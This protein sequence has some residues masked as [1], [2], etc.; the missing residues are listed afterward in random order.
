MKCI[1]VKINRLGRVR[2]SEILVSPLMVLL[3]LCIEE[4]GKIAEITL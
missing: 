3:D 2:D 4:Y 1:K